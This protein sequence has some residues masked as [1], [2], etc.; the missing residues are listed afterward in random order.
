MNLNFEELYDSIW[1][2]RLAFFGKKGRL[3]F[4]TSVR[5]HKPHKKSYK[6]IL[7]EIE[8]RPLLLKNTERD[9]VKI[10][11]FSVQ[12]LRLVE[13]T[14][15]K[16]VYKFPYNPVI[17]RRLFTVLIPLPEEIVLAC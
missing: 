1:V 7:F 2:N 13:N 17:N 9:Y 14:P 10:F 12:E 8:M 4:I 6:K 11:T 5:Q 16:I 15:T 3:M